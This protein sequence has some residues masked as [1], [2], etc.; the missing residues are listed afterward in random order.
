MSVWSV[1]PDLYGNT[2][3][4]LPRVLATMLSDA[5]G[6]IEREKMLLWNRHTIEGQL[7]VWSYQ[8]TDA[9]G[10]PRY[11]RLTRQNKSKTNKNAEVMDKIEC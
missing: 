8:R 7:L 11:I 9:N 3:V 2:K 5:G 10:R 4:L 6:I 1:L